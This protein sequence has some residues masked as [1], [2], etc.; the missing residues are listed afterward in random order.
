MKFFPDLLRQRRPRDTEEEGVPRLHVRVR[1]ARRAHPVRGDRFLPADATAPV[2][3][4]G[5]RDAGPAAP[6][7][8]AA[9]LPR[10]EGAERQRD[11]AS[12]AGQPR[13][14]QSRVEAKAVGPSPAER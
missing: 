7:V 2:A 13:A 5:R 10:G 6:A 1:E 9:E 14:P 3:D 11:R 8:L 12:G 4:A